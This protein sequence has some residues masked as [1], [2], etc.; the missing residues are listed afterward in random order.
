MS[1]LR[2]RSSLHAAKAT[3]ALLQP[4][5]GIVRHVS[6]VSGQFT[7]SVPL[8]LAAVHMYCTRVLLSTADHLVSVRRQY[9]YVSYCTYYVRRYSTPYVVAI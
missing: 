3:P 9:S 2:V 7:T 5:G 6:L 4:R 1:G 8:L